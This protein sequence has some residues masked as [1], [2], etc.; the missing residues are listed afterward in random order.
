MGKGERE[1][2]MGLEARNGK[3]SFKRREGLAF[4]YC[5]LLPYNNSGHQQ[6]EGEICVRAR[7][8]YLSH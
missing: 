4:L 6:G 3:K 1:R 7:S 2:K 8:R 5:C